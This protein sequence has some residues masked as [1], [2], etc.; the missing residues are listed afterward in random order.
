MKFF[1]KDSQLDE[2]QEKRQLKIESNCYWVAWA[3]LLVAIFLQQTLD[4]P[5]SQ[6]AGEFVI[7]MLMSVYGLVASLKNGIWDRH[8][9]PNSKTNVLLA[10]L[11]GAFVTAFF[12]FCNGI[13]YGFE[14]WWVNLLLGGV[15]AVLIFSLLQ[16]CMGVYKKRHD[17]L[18]N[19]NEDE[20]INEEEEK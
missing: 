6:Y 19:E 7:F 17:Q 2:M 3:A 18:E 1:R 8:F 10:L 16:F 20:T 14:F 11:S 15:A 12:M 4:A 13:K 5:V 9:S